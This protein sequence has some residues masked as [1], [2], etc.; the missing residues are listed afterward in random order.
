MKQIKTNEELVAAYRSYLTAN[1]HAS[2]NEAMG[3]IGT[4]LKRLKQLQDAGLITLPPKRSFSAAG[5][6]SNK[7]ARS[8]GRKWSL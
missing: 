5:T 4:N 6:R 8:N 2:T 3:A 7:I 1:P